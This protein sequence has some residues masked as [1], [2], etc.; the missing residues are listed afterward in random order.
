MSLVIT[1][2]LQAVANDEESI[3]EYTIVTDDEDD[4]E[5]LIPMEG[6][7]SLV[8]LGS[9]IVVAIIFYI[10]YQQEWCCATHRRRQRRDATNKDHQGTFVCAV[11]DSSR[12]YM[13]LPIDISS[14]LIYLHTLFYCVMP[15]EV[16]PEQAITHIPVKT[17][18]DSTA[19]DRLSPSTLHD[20]EG[21][22]PTSISP[23]S[24]TL[25]TNSSIASSSNNSPNRLSQLATI[26]RCV[27]CSKP[28][29]I[30]ESVTHSSNPSC[31]HEYHATCLTHHWATLKKGKHKKY[32]GTCPVCKEPYVIA[33]VAP[34]KQF[35]QHLDHSHNHNMDASIS[36]SP[37]DEE[38]VPVSSSS[39]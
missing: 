34:S 12:H 21:H 6:V 31:H 4:D 16:D 19:L 37:F 25:T 26:P 15:T 38:A 22:G 9:A 2:I 35:S 33:E 10:S 1:R 8:I 28:Y 11:V 36:I 27:L 29:E 20:L 3:T 17:F 14:T 7:M 32:E 13:I 39:G 23:S 5:Y 18:N 30:G 24:T